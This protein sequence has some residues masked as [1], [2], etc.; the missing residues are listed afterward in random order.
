[1]NTPNATHAEVVHVLREWGQSIRDDWGSID[2]RSCRDALDRLANHLA[3]A[4][5]HAEADATLT[6]V[7]D[8]V[9]VCIL[10]QGHWQHYC[11]DYGCD[12]ETGETI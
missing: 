7:R 3:F 4:H 2:G 9:G 1:M 6:R 10:G 5:E 8:D 12:A 11:E